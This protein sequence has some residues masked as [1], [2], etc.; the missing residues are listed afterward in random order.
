MTAYQEHL[1]TIQE[2]F[3]AALSANHFSS[4]LIYA[5][6]PRTAFLDDN[7]YPFRVNPLFKY[8][9]PVTDSPKSFIFY[10]P[11][12]RPQLFLFQARDFW[13]AAPKLPP[14]EWQEEFQVTLVDSIEQ[15]KAQ[16]ADEL[17]HTALLGELLDPVANWPVRA[18]NPAGLINYLHYQRAWKTAYEVSCL[19]AANDLAVRGHVAAR[20]AF[21]AGASE[22]DIQREYLSA[23]KFREHQVPYNSIIALNEHSAVLH[24]DVY[25][26]E[27]PAEHRSFLIDAGATY[28]GYCADITR[29]YASETTG[30]YPEL[31][32][33][34]DAAEQEIIG[35][36]ETGM[37]YYDLH[38]T[39][40]LKI[41]R[42]LREF[43]FFSLT[44]E[45]IYQR[46]Y[47][48]AFFPHGLGHY[49]GLQVHDVGGFLRSPTGDAH[50]RDS[51]HPFLRLLR[52]IEPGQVF[53]IE[54][55]LYIVDQL[56][57]EFQG[58]TDFNWQRVDELRP[59]GGVRV[60]DSVL[61]TEQGTENLT[62]KAFQALSEGA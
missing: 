33:A 20:Q 53:T 59:Y 10:R 51:R 28:N 37:S 11:G 23:M 56:L 50:E 24:Y 9:L 46:G 21:A 22:L 42:I 6:H 45:E 1:K 12:H 54:P 62:R 3:D 17:P 41:A 61:V 18:Q 47:T 55:G 60:E 13:H 5:G 19:Q 40:H 35:Q 27:P 57:E 48:N 15:V 8:W 30:F 38:V 39:M 26:T 49:I 4:V 2:R 36:I 58:N 52:P 32:A 44:P 16:L 31:V 34:V 14:G 25:D 43:G 29:T 7:A